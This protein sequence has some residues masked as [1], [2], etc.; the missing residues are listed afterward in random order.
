MSNR[1]KKFLSQFFQKLILRFSYFRSMARGGHNVPSRSRGGSR[2]HNSDRSRNG[3]GANPTNGGSDQPRTS[4]R[5]GTRGQ[6]SRGGGAGPVI[7]AA[8]INRVADICK[9]S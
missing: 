1:H 5:G 9:Y 2:N 4:I 8:S 6:S 7:S 3:Q